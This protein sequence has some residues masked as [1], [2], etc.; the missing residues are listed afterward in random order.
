MGG[1]SLVISLV[2]DS[3]GTPVEVGSV[4]EVQATRTCDI[5][6]RAKEIR[7]RNMIT[8]LHRSIKRESVLPMMS[9]YDL[10]G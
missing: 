1:Y 2:V 5:I 9:D 7:L 3:V 10:A 6:V 4:L 8:S